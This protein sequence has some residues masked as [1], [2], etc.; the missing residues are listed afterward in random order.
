M[1]LKNLR[2]CEVCDHVRWAPCSIGCAIPPDNNP[3]SWRLNLQA[4]AGTL[5]AGTQ[6][7]RTDANTQGVDR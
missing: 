3:E 4:G 6:L 2:V 7:P 5:T 1:P